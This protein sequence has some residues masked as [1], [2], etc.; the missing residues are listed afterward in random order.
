MT[1]DEALL[2]STA[3]A[4]CG[5]VHE[6]FRDRR[7]ICP[8]CGADYGHPMLVPVRIEVTPES[9]IELVNKVNLQ[10]TWVDGLVADAQLE[11]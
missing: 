4:Y 3:C 11:S 2:G 6:I 7:N 9:D 8:E 10:L 5:R 1:R